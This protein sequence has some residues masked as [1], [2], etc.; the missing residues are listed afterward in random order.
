[1][2]YSKF[3]NTNVFDDDSQCIREMGNS[4]D[5]WAGERS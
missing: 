2:V 1:M 5:R 4:Y 3:N